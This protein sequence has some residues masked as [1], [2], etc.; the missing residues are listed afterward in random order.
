MNRCKIILSTILLVSVFS[1]Q[2]KT[3]NGSDKETDHSLLEKV[4]STLQITAKQYSYLSE[5]VKL[6]EYP[7]TFENDTLVTSNSGWWCSGFYPGTL[8]YLDEVLGAPKLKKEA[9]SF[10]DDLKREQTNTDTHDLGFMMYC[11]FGNANR[12]E[13]NK[14]YQTIL[15]NSA[16]SLSTR[17]HDKVKAIRSW[18]SEPWNDAGEGDL[19]VIIDNMMNLELL[20]W[21]TEHSNDSTYYDIAI[22]H[23]ETTLKNHFRDDNSS[24]HQLIYDEET[25]NVKA[26]ITRQGFADASAWA[27]GQA[28]GLYGYTVM[29]RVTKDKKYL[30]QAKHI[31]DFILTHPN[32]PE[33]KIPYWDFNAPNIPNAYRDSSAAAIIASALIELSGYVEDEKAEVYK[34]N[35]KSMLESLLS[36]EYFADY[37]ENGG[38]LLKH[39]VGH[40]PAN[41]E[42][43]VP[44]SYGD[45]YLVEAMLRYKKLKESIN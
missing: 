23:A 2:Q 6:G 13:A 19:V 10:L 14:D 21:A 36:P 40:K 25:G 37:K 35:A 45:Y 27:R 12:L 5:Q 32:L 22:N 44:L 24:Y 26:K 8:L 38:F 16:K 17:Y 18:N 15:M 20:F 1:C 4:D 43:D 39:G 9:I 11:S 30:N 31:A 29:Y 41:S 3:K 34:G 28:W 7:R 42:V 33:D